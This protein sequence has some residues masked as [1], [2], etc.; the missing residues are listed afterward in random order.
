MTFFYELNKKLNNIRTDEKQLTES[1]FAP[2]TKS[3]VRKTLE[4][5]LAQDLK[6]L[7]EDG[8]GG[9]NFSGSG[10][11]EE[12]WAGGAKLNPA[13]KGMF[14]GKSKADLESEL[15]KLHKSGPHK[16]GSPEYTKQQELNFAIRAKSEWKESVME[17]EGNFENALYSTNGGFSGWDEHNPQDV[18]RWFGEP[19]DSPIYR[20]LIQAMKNGGKFYHFD[21]GEGGYD[22]GD[23]E[24]AYDPVTGK[25]YVHG[26]EESSVHD[27]IGSAMEV[28]RDMTGGGAGSGG[29]KGPSRAHDTLSGRHEVTPDR[30]RKTD[31]TGRK[32]TISGG[33]AN[34][35]KAQ[36]GYNLGKHPKPKKLPEAIPMTLEEKEMMKYL[37]KK[38]AKEDALSVPVNS[39]K[40]AHAGIEFED[41]PHGKPQWLIDAQKKAEKRQGK[42][43]EVDESVSRKHFQAIADTL[44]HI[45]D[46]EKRRELAQHHASA[47]KLANPRFD[48]EK[49]M[50]ACDL[51]E[52]WEE[53]VEESAWDYKSPRPATSSGK[54]DSKK[55]STGTVYTRK[56]ETFIDEPGDEVGE[57]GVKR[58]RGRPAK[59]KPEHRFT[60]GAWKNKDP[61]AEH[62]N[63]DMTKNQIHTIRR[64]ARALESI[65]R[66]DEEVPEWVKSKITIAND[67][68]KTVRDYLESAMERS[69]E[70][71]SGKEGITSE[72]DEKITKKTPAGEII[73]DFEKSKNKKF[74]GD[75][76]EERKERALGAYYG[77]HPEKSKKEESVKKDNKA[78]KAGKKV[79]KDIEYDEGHKGKDDNKA[80]KAGKKVAKDI[81]YDEKKKLKKEE[82]VEETT[83]SGSIATSAPKAGKDGMGVGKGIYDSI[84]RQ[85]ESMIS[86]SFDVDMSKSFS[87]QG[88]AESNITVHAQGAEADM[89]KELLKNAGI[90][91]AA[92]T[93]MSHDHDD[94]CNDCGCSPCECVDEHC[95]PEMIE[96]ELDEADVTVSD[97]E[98]DWP[99]NNEYSDDA[100]Q[101]SGGLNK[102]KRTVAGDG[103]TTVPVT[104][105]QVAEEV[106]IE[107]SLFDLY[108]AIEQ[109]TYKV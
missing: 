30:L 51:E 84:N 55:I 38:A 9:M 33:H 32:G 100:L 4:T 87:D 67:Y 80:E 11:L 105:V 69:A 36:I 85:V 79:T 91:V 44:R 5:S 28:I 99:T 2:V 82:K 102:P 86:E 35:L 94:S 7:M 39:R 43:V 37:S 18:I 75:S 101:Y 31:R 70:R 29:G 13:K 40:P 68:L 65:V 17:G 88:E 61:L 27:T 50:K 49:F 48:Y 42:N 25:I 89:L 92:D 90:D 14:K 52:C 60:K 16:K 53:G 58:G 1:K 6:K 72:L 83:T 34:N 107:R 10:S 64:A 97:N 41:G 93:R 8:T 26:H 45:E 22:L 19:K 54:F 21:D 23:G 66:A 106:T 95:H 78:E 76:K 77:M 96:L 71:M 59:A 73:K 104:A 15:A 81:E 109:R 12:K 63:D 108:K 103:Q 74:A 20:G 3:P 62:D 56:P 24:V 47:F 98:P 46:V 57:P